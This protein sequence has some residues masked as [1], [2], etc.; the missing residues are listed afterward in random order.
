MNRTPSIL[1]RSGENIR[2]HTETLLFRKPHAASETLP[3]GMVNEG[4]GVYCTPRPIRC[5]SSCTRL[6]EESAAHGCIVFLAPLRIVK[7]LYIGMY[8]VERWQEVERFHTLG[9]QDENR[10]V[11]GQRCERI[12]VILI[13]HHHDD[14]FRVTGLRP[15]D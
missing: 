11:S 8:R 5:I 1:F 12:V 15:D 9:E 7:R 2:T 10:I 13:I 6:S 3:E 4:R 14:R